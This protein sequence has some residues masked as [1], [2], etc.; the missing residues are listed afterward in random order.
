MGDGSQRGV[1]VEKKISD[2]NIVGVE[3]GGSLH[4]SVTLTSS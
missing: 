1:G 3:K 2:L 4:G